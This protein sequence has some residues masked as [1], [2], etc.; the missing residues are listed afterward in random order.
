MVNESARACVLLVGVV[1]SAPPSLPP[2]TKCTT[3]DR[4]AALVHRPS[5]SRASDRSKQGRSQSIGRGSVF[6]AAPK[7]VKSD[8]DDGKYTNAT[9][10]DGLLGL[11]F[12][13]KA[14]SLVASL[15]QR[16]DMGPPKL[17]AL[18]CVRFR[19]SLPNTDTHRS[20]NMMIRRQEARGGPLDLSRWRGSRTGSSPHHRTSTDATTTSSRALLPPHRML[21]AQL[22]QVNT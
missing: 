1:S 2:K 3:L 22:R 11:G 21:S 5:N 6:I 10:T 14:L 7:D 19:L 18:S 13:G 16:T 4:A 8:S 12:G 20:T 15:A 17:P 9:T